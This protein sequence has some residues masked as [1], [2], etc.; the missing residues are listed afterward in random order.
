MFRILVV[1]VV[2]AGCATRNEKPQ[3]ADSAATANAVQRLEGKTMR[4][5]KGPADILGDT[6]KNQRSYLKRKE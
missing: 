4:T 1:T 2:L 6:T 5:F 3:A